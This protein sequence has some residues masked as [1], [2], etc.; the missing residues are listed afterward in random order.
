MLDREGLEAAVEEMNEHSRDVILEQVAMN[1]E[2]YVSAED[3]PG[4]LEILGEETPLEYQCD[5]NAY[6][7]WALKAITDKAA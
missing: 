2:D 6:L 1:W 7:A 5:I 3:L 4:L